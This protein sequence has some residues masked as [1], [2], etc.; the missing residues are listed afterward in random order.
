MSEAQRKIEEQEMKKLVEQRKREKQEDR[1][2][3]Y[4]FLTFRYSMSNSILQFIFVFFRER[5]KAQIEADKA[6]RRE[7]M[8]R[9]V[10]DPFLYAVNVVYFVL[11]LLSLSAYI[12]SVE[13]PIHQKQSPLLN[14]LQRRRHRRQQRQHHHRHQVHRSHMPI[15][16]FK[17]VC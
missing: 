9:Y 12:D 8:A 5:V 6:A 11:N 10:L 13:S 7:Q 17:S 4:F 1:L 14:H 16:E 2:A 3:R 15:H